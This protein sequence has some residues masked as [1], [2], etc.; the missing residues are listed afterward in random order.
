M[1]AINPERV[2][3]PNLVD[4]TRIQASAKLESFGLKVGHIS[5]EPNIAI[6]VVLVQRINGEE[7][8]A[9]DSVIKGSSIDLVLGNGLSD[10]QAAIPNLIGLS[11]E[12][13]KT[14]AL[15]RNLNIGASVHDQTII[16]PED[17]IQAVIFKQKPEPLPG[18]TLPLGSELM[19][20]LHLILPR[21]SLSFFRRFIV[22]YAMKF[23][24]NI[25]ICFIFFYCVDLSAQRLQSLLE[26]PVLKEY[27][28]RNPARLKSTSATPLTLHFLRIFLP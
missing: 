17:E 16:K 3:M 2:A 1:N 26:N 28:F 22:R 11:L 27:R 8:I 9:G 20:G 4:L 23:I 13:A 6:N 5:Y 21:L 12:E 10:E 18:I 19:Y 14:K 25:L 7:I 24:R 15:D